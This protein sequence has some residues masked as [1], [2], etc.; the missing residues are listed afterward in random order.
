VAKLS[1]FYLVTGPYMLDPRSYG[2]TTLSLLR[3][4]Q[5]SKTG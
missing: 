4:D 3:G 5:P 1:L 2:S